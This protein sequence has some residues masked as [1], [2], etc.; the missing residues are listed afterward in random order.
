MKHEIVNYEMIKSLR[1]NPI[2]PINFEEMMDDLEVEIIR[3]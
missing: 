1:F 3:I 2:R